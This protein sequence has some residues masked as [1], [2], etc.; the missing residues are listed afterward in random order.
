[1]TQ[2][3][4]NHYVPE[5]YQHRFI[6]DI[7]NDKRFYYLDMK[8]ELIVNGDIRYRRKALL[9]WGPRN[10]FFQENLYTTKFGNMTSTEIEEKFFG[11]IDLLGQK[12]MEY[13]ANFDHTTI[14]KDALKNIMTYLSV[15]KLRTPK[16]LDYLS[17][18][19]KSKDNRLLFKMQELR[20]LYCATWCECI[21][22]I[23]DAS[24]SK[25]K[26]L[27]S[28]HPVSV[29]NKECFPRSEWCID[30]K[31]PDIRFVGTHTFIPL[32]LEKILILTNLLYVRYPYGNPIELR[33]NARWF[34]PSMFNFLEIQIGRVL[35]DI[36]VIEINYIIKSRA[37]RYIA[38]VEEEWLYPERYMSNPPWDKFG[39]EYLLMPDPRAVSFS[40]QVVV[41][42]ERG[43]EV[44]DEYGRKP[45]QPGYD[46]K[47][48]REKEWQTSNAF[49]GEYARL[50]GPKRRGYCYEYGKIGNK[51]D[52]PEMHAIHLKG[53]SK[54]KKYKI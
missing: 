49:K 42:Y 34:R 40:T 46:E 38:A 22:C 11:K 3:T 25:T 28:D 39:K 4:R 36:E 33:P 24:T 51:E 54:Y 6:P 32:N 30:N 1:M 29:Y 15:Q 27:L 48:Q 52:S 50:F 45:W 17:S 19:T 37:Y 12:A 35:S 43:S 21:W 5:W 2:Y 10:C 16:G 8:P 23:A 41:G 44:F 14:D 20:D 7:K 31:D 13:F 53:E 47:S 9:R 26:F 18:I